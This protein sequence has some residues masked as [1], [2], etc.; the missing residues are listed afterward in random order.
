MWG[1]GHLPLFLLCSPQLVLLGSNEISAT[2]FYEIIGFLT[3]RALIRWIRLV[4]HNIFH[5]APGR[6]QV[7]IKRWICG[8]RWILA[9]SPLGALIPNV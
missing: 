5:P 6:S 3:Q 2:R 7:A 4:G 1:P 8:V 9:K